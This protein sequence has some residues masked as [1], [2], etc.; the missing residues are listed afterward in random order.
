MI[1]LHTARRMHF[2]LLRIAV[3][4]RY[5][6]HAANKMEF[7]LLIFG[8][9][10]FVL[11]CHYLWTFQSHKG[12]WKTERDGSRLCSAKSVAHNLNPCT[13]NLNLCIMVLRNHLA[14]HINTF[15]QSVEKRSSR[16]AFFP[17]EWEVDWY[18]CVFGTEWVKSTSQHHMLKN[19]ILLH[20]NPYQ[21]INGWSK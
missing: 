19:E 18:M 4:S 14:W 20:Y 1:N 17:K 11:I 5:H 10:I 16:M 13:S 3:T 21:C 15:E 8:L 12:L 6:L 9:N 2:I 7:T